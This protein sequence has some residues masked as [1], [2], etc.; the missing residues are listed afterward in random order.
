M[1]TKLRAEHCIEVVLQV[2]WKIGKADIFLPLELT[3]G[4]RYGRDK[5]GNRG[6]GNNLC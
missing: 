4:T 5:G 3:T 1:L 6:G 2:S